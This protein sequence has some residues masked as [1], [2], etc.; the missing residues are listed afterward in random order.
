MLLYQA[1]RH[2]TESQ[3]KPF[4]LGDVCN[5][6]AGAFYSTVNVLDREKIL[7]PVTLFPSVRKQ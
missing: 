2:L 7:N 6:Y 4:V 3:L 1:L 5:D